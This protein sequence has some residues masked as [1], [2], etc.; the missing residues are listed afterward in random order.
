MVKSTGCSSRGPEFESSLVYKMSSRT[1]RV[2]QR[3]PVS[4]NQK[5]KKKKT[6]QTKKTTKK[7]IKLAA[8][9]S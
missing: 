4:K 7:Q 6:N 3:N 2:T 9:N 5:K 8:D 1:A